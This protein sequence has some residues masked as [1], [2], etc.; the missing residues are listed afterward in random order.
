MSTDHSNPF[1]PPQADIASTTTPTAEQ[2]YPLTATAV[3]T[4]EDLPA[5]HDGKVRTL[6]IRFLMGVANLFIRLA[7]VVPFY[8]V[9]AYVPAWLN[10]GGNASLA[11]LGI[12]IIVLFTLLFLI[13][14][15]CEDQWWEYL[16]RRQ[17]RSRPEP[18]LSS[19]AHRSRY[20]TL[21]T[22]Q[23]LPMASFQLGSSEAEIIDIGLLEL[24]KQKSEVV[25][26]CDKRRYRI[27]RNSLLACDVQQIK[28]Q[29]PWT[30]VVRLACQ[31]KEGP[32]EFCILPGDNNPWRVFTTRH[33]K[34]QAEQLASDIEDLPTSD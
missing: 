30:P 14:A 3:A 7:I 17:V 11:I 33:R 1:A 24:D 13:N 9:V 21:T 18:W 31:T 6:G 5:E 10:L 12:G 29:S 23:P 19:E 8:F 16:M 2:T 32:L 20:V 15:F 4:I 22:T 28:L 34:Q 26:E 27:P 25:L